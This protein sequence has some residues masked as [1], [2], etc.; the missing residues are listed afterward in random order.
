MVEG[1]DWKRTFRATTLICSAVI[2]GIFLYAV[3]LEILKSRLAFFTGLA[4]PGQAR[5]LL[6]IF[7]GLAVAS[8]VVTRALNRSLMKKKPAE[9]PQTT[10]QRLSRA[11][12]V[13]AVAAEIPALLGF[14]LFLLTGSSKNFYYLLF[15]SLILEFI[16]FPRL[17]TWQE[18]L[19][20]Q[21]PAESG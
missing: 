3:I 19:G 5:T 18:I 13:T 17:G 8:I 20:E 6:F 7:Y 21:V 9:S 16:F 10:I 14:V 12:V 15:V 2:A 11:A 4:R 1:T